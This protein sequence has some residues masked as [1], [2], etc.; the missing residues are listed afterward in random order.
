MGFTIIL[1]I[2]FVLCLI[3]SLILFIVNTTNNNEGLQ[4]SGFICSLIFALGTIILSVE[5]ISILYKYNTQYADRQKTLIDRG[6]LERKLKETYN[7]GNLNDAIDF[8]GTQNKIKIEN[9]TFLQKYNTAIYYVDTIE[10]PDVKFTPT[11]R[12][13]L[14]H[15]DK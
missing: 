5:S 14:E 15:S 9:S 3:L 4:I 6:I 1:L 8:N 10:I 2:G 13:E 12:I 11:Q 7:Q